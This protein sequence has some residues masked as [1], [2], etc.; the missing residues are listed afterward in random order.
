MVD[1]VGGIEVEAEGWVTDQGRPRHEASD[2]LFRVG[3]GG[4]IE[5][6]PHEIIFEVLGRV[7]RDVG[8]QRGRVVGD[9]GEEGGLRAH[10]PV[11]EIGC[12]RIGG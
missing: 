11:Q 8:F 7:E 4:G 1:L 12:E 9:A 10:G 5:A 6:N 3:G 2:P